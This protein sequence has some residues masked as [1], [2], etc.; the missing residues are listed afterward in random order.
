MTTWNIRFRGLPGIGLINAGDDLASM[1][2]NAADADSF[3]FAHNDVVVVAQKV[4]SKAENRIVDL[5]SV[6]PTARAK[7]LAER[8]GRDPRLCQLYLDESRAILNVKGRHVVTVDN[9]GFQGTGAGVD[10]SN[11][12]PRHEGRA[13][14]LPVDPDASARRI[15]DGIRQQSGV[16][17]AVIISDS[18]GSDLRDGAYGAAIG[19]A[20]IRHVEEPEGSHDLFRTPSRPIIN[21]VDEI[22]SAASIV[23]GQT[24]AGLPVIVGRGIE[25]TVDE[26]A[27]IAR[28]IVGPPLPEVDFDLLSDV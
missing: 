3:A 16:T 21:R 23:M 14:L 22:A 15:R 18:F 9:R 13:V 1:I 17:V 8:T 11:V 24:D 2:V 25:Y 10:M 19:I 28:L 26:D 5:A 20:G 7:R 4:V 27:A 6:T 12:G